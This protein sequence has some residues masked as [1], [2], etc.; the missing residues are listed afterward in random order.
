MQTK[1]S[2]WLQTQTVPLHELKMPLGSLLMPVLKPAVQEAA[3]TWAVNKTSLGIVDEAGLETCATGCTGSNQA[4]QQASPAAVVLLA[5]VM[6]IPVEAG[7]GRLQKWTSSRICCGRRSRGVCLRH[8]YPPS[9]AA[10][11][12]ARSCV[13]S[14]THATAALPC[15]NRH[16][17]CVPTLAAVHLRS[18]KQP[19]LRA[20]QSS[21]HD[22]KQLTFMQLAFAS[23]LAS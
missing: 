15:S 3:D 2:S 21:A 1:P 6:W 4:S 9:S 11:C 22:I 19:Q 10:H 16:Y 12:Q 20:C 23:L 14:T 13:R 7:D 5:I 18:F 8:R 17:S